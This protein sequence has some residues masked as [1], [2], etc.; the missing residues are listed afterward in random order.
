MKRP[1]RR[2]HKSQRN[3]LDGAIQ[4]FQHQW[5]TNRQFRATWSGVLALLMIVLLCSSV[6]VV[7]AVATRALAAAGLGTGSGTAATT[8]SAPAGPGNATAG[9]QTADTFPTPTSTPGNPGQV[10]P[11][12]PIPDSLT[13]VPSPTG[14]PTATP[15]PTA[16]ATATNGGG[17]G[18]GQ[19]QVCSGGLGNGT[20][21]LNPCPVVHGQSGTLSI[22]DPGDA[23]KQ[24]NIV[25]SFSSSP[26]CTDCTILQTPS[27]SNALDGGGNYTLSFTVP[28]DVPVGSGP[29]S[30]MINVSGGASTTFVSP[31]AK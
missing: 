23:G 12:S 25:L 4:R 29:V 26:N 2:R 24:L 8:A 6:G 16:A 22:S 30:G 1:S 11:A 28:S 9:G 15:A 18:S 7:G 3:P 14:Q 27:P 13:P 17:G 5:E 10:P 20:W 19:P 31:P 21:R